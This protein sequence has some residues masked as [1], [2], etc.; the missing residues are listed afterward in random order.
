MICWFA[1]TTGTCPNDA[2]MIKVDNVPAA[3]LRM[4]DE[5]VGHCVRMINRFSRSRYAIVTEAAIR[6]GKRIMVYFHRFRPVACSRVVTVFAWCVRG[7]MA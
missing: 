5:A 4:A 3:V 2:R 6:V 1:V 7:N